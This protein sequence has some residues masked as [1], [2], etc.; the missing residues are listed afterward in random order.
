MKLPA[1]LAPALWGAAGGAL[2]LAALG[3]TWFGWVGPGTAHTKATARVNAAV[4][5]V[6]TPICLEK[7]RASDDA[8]ARLAA[9]KKLKYWE[10]AEFVEKGGWATFAGMEKPNTDVARACATAIEEQ[11]IALAKP[12]AESKST[13]Q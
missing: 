12:D 11:G 10:K 4:V 5:A 3:F 7:F 1:Q 13:N 9:L 8:P 6:L 2:V